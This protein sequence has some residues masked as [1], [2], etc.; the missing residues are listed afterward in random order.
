MKRILPFILLLMLAI[1]A[2]DDRPNDVLSRGK[3]ED[4]LYDYHLMQGI[5][6]QLP[7]EERTEKAQDYIN[8]VYEKHGITEAQ[9]DSS[10]VYYNRHTKDLYKIYNNLKERYTAAN[11]EIQIV[12]GNNDM[13]AIFATGGDT[14][15]LWNSSPLLMLRNKDLAKVESFT[16]LAD[17][18]FHRQD[19]FIMTFTPIF[20]KESQDYYDISLC[21]GLSIHYNDNTQQGISR[22]ITYN[23]TQQLTLK[24]N[25]EHDIQSIT[26][27]FYYKG[28]K[29]TRNLCLVEDISLV[30]MH[31]KEA[32]PIVKK[33]TI[34]ADTIKTDTALQQPARRLS[35][36]EIR[37]QNKSN[38]HISIQAAPSVRTP[39]TMGP[40]RRKSPN[41]QK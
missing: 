34:K 17:T 27:F 21:V 2:C 14:T 40:R 19:Q 29:N 37:L 16:I 4:V 32:V 5:I 12:N 23:G 13:M 7:S 35:P 33:D 39:N 11:E 1:A 8:A 30:R 3:M 15:N 24:A 36:E 22:N 41:R 25:A 6:D 26:G 31:Q 9:F 38:E 20:M 18:S 28:K 10:V